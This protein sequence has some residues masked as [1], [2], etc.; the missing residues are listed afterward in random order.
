MIANR[1]RKKPTHPSA[2][3]P[4]FHKW[5]PVPA[6]ASKAPKSPLQGLFFVSTDSV[7]TGVIFASTS[8]SLPISITV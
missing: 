5:I 6:Q 8:M 1:M 7:D 3:F 2:L 4:P